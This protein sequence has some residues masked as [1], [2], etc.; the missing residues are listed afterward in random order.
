V[1]LIGWENTLQI[2]VAATETG[3][4]DEFKE[5]REQVNDGRS[6]LDVRF[7]EYLGVVGVWDSRYDIA[8]CIRSVALSPQMCSNPDSAPPLVGLQAASRQWLNEPAE[9]PVAYRSSL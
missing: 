2:T 6:V 3:D 9:K 8:L 1:Y 7:L 5:H 4:H